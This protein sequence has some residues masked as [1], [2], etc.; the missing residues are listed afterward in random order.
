[1]WEKPQDERKGIG[2]AIRGGQ[3]EKKKNGEGEKRRKTKIRRRANLRI[4]G[5]PPFQPRGFQQNLY[6]CYKTDRVRGK[7]VEL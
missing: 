1:M 2:A 5:G 7:T 3:R 4:R 6:S